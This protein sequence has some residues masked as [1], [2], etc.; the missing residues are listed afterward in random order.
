MTSFQE[1][2]IEDVNVGYEIVVDGRP[3]TV[4]QCWPETRVWEDRRGTVVVLDS[5]DELFFDECE[6]VDARAHQLPTVDRFV[7]LNSRQPRNSRDRTPRSCWV[8]LDG[9][10]VGSVADAGSKHFQ[11][12]H[13]Y[14]W[15][16]WT[17]I[18]CY[19]IPRRTALEMLAD[20]IEK[21]G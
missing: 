11:S 2:L 4:A 3:R 10:L 8:Y 6:V 14:D 16:G 19:E 20:R 1:M 5:N 17:F 13:A 18:N 7:F 21:G 15:R 12:I 9:Q